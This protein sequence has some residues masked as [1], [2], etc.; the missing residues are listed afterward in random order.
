MAGQAHGAHEGELVCR[1]LVGGD[2]HGDD[3]G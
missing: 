3:T 2:Q 1:G